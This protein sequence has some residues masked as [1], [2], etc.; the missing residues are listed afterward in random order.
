M[1]RSYRL[2]GT[3]VLL[4]LA[5]LA[6][7]QAGCGSSNSTKTS[8]QPMDITSGTWTITV[9]PAGGGGTST[10]TAT[11]TTFACSNTNV[12]IG[13][14]W[15][16]PN[17]FST[18]AG[19]CVTGGAPTSKT[20]GFTPQGLVFEVGANPVPANGTTTFTSGA[21]FFASLNSDGVDSDLYDLT[22][23]FTASSKGVS[24]SYSCDALCTTC[25]GDSGTFSGTMN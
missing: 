10:M 13:P 8:S 11:F 23:T 6:L 15:Y 4:C 18:S 17:P 1:K 7:F 19:V 22:G 2:F 21:A 24:G 9:T 25:T 16:D 12:Y 5:G 20:S 14:D 3:L